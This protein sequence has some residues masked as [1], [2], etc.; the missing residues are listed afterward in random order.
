MSNF[1]NFSLSSAP[2]RPRTQ[3]SEASA[4]LWSVYRWMSLGLAV[5]GLTAFYVASSPEAV[6]IIYGNKLLFFG[7]IIAQLGLVIAFSPVA[8]RTSTS[9]AG[10]MFLGYSALTGVTLSSIFLAYSQA[11]IAQAFFVTAA[12]FAGLS[13][14]GA[15]TKRDLSAMGRFMVIGLIGFIIASVVNIFLRSPAVYWVS[16][17]AGVLI[18]A[19]LTAWETQRLRHI[20]MSVGGAGNLALRGALI[21]YL[22]FVNLFLM[23]LRIFG[24]DRR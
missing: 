14:Y 8:M 17:Y 21:M 16:T 19:G 5:S 7:L 15:T 18:F 6:S 9:T 20:Y 22:D 3:A 24:G 4:F 1:G 23:L 10:A 11:S 13:V 2:S 12:S